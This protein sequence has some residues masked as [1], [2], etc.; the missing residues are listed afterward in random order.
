MKLGDTVKHKITGFEGVATG[1]AEYLTGCT[2]F[3]VMSR[4][5]KPDGEANVVWI[6][7]AMLIP[8]DV[9]TLSLDAPT[10]QPGGPQQYP[11]SRY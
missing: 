7:E 3:S 1:R 4:T 10:E 8:C 2:Q 9:P 5:L 11:P 6:D